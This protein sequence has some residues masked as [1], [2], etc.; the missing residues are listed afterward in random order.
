MVV[1]F[2]V[3]L[4]TGFVKAHAASQAEIEEKGVWLNLNEAQRDTFVKEVNEEKWYQGE[5]I[6]CD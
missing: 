1:F 6:R 3:I 4:G 2:G 5:F